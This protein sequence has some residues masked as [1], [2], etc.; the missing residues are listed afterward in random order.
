MNETG[1]NRELAEMEFERFCGAA[2]I[3]L[4]RYKK[5]SDLEDFNDHKDLFIEGVMDG[6]IT[7]DEEGWPTVHTECEDLKEVRFPRRPKG[8]DRCAMD[9]LPADSIH[10]RSFTWI[11]SVVGKSYKLLQALEEHDLT[12]VECV[13]NLFRD[14]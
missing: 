14:A 1:M 4:Q 2:R 3:N 10:A 5:D 7:V 12:M 13:F 6:R 8:F 9:K 11:A